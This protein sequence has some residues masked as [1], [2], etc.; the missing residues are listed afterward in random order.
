MDRKQNKPAT[1]IEIPASQGTRCTTNVKTVIMSTKVTAQASN[2]A[3]VHK[4]ILEGTSLEGSA[5]MPVL[6]V[7]N[8]IYTYTIEVEA[9]QEIGARGWVDFAK[10][11]YGENAF[12]KELISDK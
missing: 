7:G 5:T 12:C 4:S 1:F 8:A 9:Y 2:I 3:R 11:L 10:R 6:T